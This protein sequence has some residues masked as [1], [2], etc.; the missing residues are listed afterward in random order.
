MMCKRV[1]SRW[2]L[3]TL[4]TGFGLITMCIAF[5]ES[6]ETLV[7]TRVL[8]GV[9]EAGI[10]PGIVFTFSQYYKRHEIATRLGIQSSTASV[11][12]SF[13]GLLAIG[14]SSIPPCGILH[15]WR[16]IF[17]IEGVLTMLVGIFVFCVLPT[18]LA[19]A[20]FLTSEEKKVALERI[21]AEHLVKGADRFD[22]KAFKH[23]MFHVP[24]QLIGLG[25]ICSLL[26]MT[27][28]ALFMASSRLSAS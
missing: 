26:C 12:G 23:A 21:R 9:F 1:G 10:L 28:V 7:V 25:L 5:V 19:S 3:G 11:A 22:W 18:D 16:Y 2:W 4:T 24:T 27:S 8:L 20:S 6:F 14:L 15:E 17:L 13:G